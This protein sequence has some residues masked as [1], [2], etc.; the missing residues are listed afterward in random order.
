MK[1]NYRRGGLFLLPST[2]LAI[3]LAVVFNAPLP[4]MLSIGGC[5]FVTAAVLILI[6][7]RSKNTKQ[8]R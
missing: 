3:V 1:S 7:D 2:V 4:A 5:G 8:G 6:G